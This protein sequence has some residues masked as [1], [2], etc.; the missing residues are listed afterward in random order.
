MRH[1]KINDV[2]ILAFIYLVISEL[3]WIYQMNRLY[4]PITD[5]RFSAAVFFS[6][7]MRVLTI[8]NI[9]TCMWWLRVT[10][11]LGVL[12]VIGICMIHGFLITYQKWVT[13]SVGKLL[14]L[15]AVILFL[16]VIIQRYQLVRKREF[17]VWK[18]WFDMICYICLYISGGVIWC[19]WSC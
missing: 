14:L 5:F 17:W 18:K 13:G 3:V 16:L 12:P 10:I 7:L 2:F 19:F 8:M 4:Y 15:Q 1:Y 9:F 6:I 11:A